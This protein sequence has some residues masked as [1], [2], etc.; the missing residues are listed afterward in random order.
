ML[1]YLKIADRGQIIHT[2]VGIG[3]TCTVPTEKT[4]S[5]VFISYWRALRGESL[6][7]RV[8]IISAASI[9]GTKKRNRVQLGYREIEHIGI[10]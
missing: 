4:I 6:E 1:N 7:A 2:I 10:I 5:D 8:G 3:P 9:S